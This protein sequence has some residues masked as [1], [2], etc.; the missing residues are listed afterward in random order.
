MVGSM[1]PSC[2]NS[3]LLWRTG[4][5]FKSKQLRPGLPEWQCREQ[6]I[7]LRSHSCFV[8]RSQM[9]KPDTYSSRIS[10]DIPLYEVPGASFDQYLEDKPRVFNAI[11]PDKRRS[12]RLTEEEWRIQML[13]ID[14]LFVTVWPV[15]DMR[16][17]CK[18]EGT[19]Y[20]TGVTSSITK[21]IELEIIRW[22]LQG[23]DDILKPSAF[24][25]GVKGALYPDRRGA[26][27][28]L[29]GQLQMSMSF[30][31]PP[32]LA[33]VPEDVRRNVA[34]SV[35]NRLVENMKH[36]VNSSLLADYSKFKRE[37]LKAMV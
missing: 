7:E 10:T 3:L 8:I 21:V 36:K 4:L 6:R 19:D 20:P 23:L 18:A 27:T 17:R 2:N 33:L 37:K 29:K 31:L 13:P 5:Q 26:R 30:A 14:F 28:R 1:V 22:E 11:F 32:V 16:L 24:T 25:L 35:L 9:V 34:E 12:Q 15:I